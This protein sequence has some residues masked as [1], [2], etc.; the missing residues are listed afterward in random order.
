[1]FSGGGGG[2]KRGTWEKFVSGGVKWPDML[3]HDI[4]VFGKNPQGPINALTGELFYKPE[5]L[6]YSDLAFS[7]RKIHVMSPAPPPDNRN[8]N[9]PI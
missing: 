8:A 9:K 7:K 6:R 4:G 1:M 3:N 2:G 5:L